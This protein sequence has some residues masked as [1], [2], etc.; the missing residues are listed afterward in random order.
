MAIAVADILYGGSKNMTVINMSEYKEEHKV[1]LL[2]GSPPGYVGYGDGGVLTD[3]VRRQPYNIVLLDEIEKANPSVQDIFYQVFDKGMLKDGQGRDIDFKNTV[4]IMTSNACTDYLEKYQEDDIEEESIKTILADIQQP[5][6]RYFKAA[7]LGRTTLIPF[8]TLSKE[9]LIKIIELKTRGVIQRIKLH[10]KATLQIT[11]E[12]QNYIIDQC[13][14]KYVGA[15][16]IDNII[17]GKMLTAIS[18]TILQCLGEERSFNEIIVTIND[19][20]DISATAKL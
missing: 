16:Q 11:S 8:H 5:L 19:E 6:Q 13:N 14:N 2:T 17:N 4:I 15:R 1:S 9:N 18:S 7:F 10:Y 12:V 20:G 3:A